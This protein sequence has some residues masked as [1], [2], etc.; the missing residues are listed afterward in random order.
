MSAEIPDSPERRARLAVSEYQGITPD[1]EMWSWNAE[2]LRK[3]IAACEG[4]SFDPEDARHHGWMHVEYATTVAFVAQREG[5][6]EAVKD[7]VASLCNKAE[8]ILRR[9][10][11]DSRHD[12]LLEA[13]L[14]RDA[15]AALV[16][17]SFFT[18]DRDLAE[19]YR[20]YRDR[21]RGALEAAL[22]EF[23]STGGVESYAH[24]HAAMLALMLVGQESQY[25]PLP[26]PP[27]ASSFTTDTKYRYDVLLMGSKLVA[28]RVGED[29][30]PWR[31]GLAYQDFVPSRPR[32]DSPSVATE[33]A[34]IGAPAH[35][36]GKQVKPEVKAVQ[37]HLVETV[38]AQLASLTE[39]VAAPPVPENHF[40]WYTTLTPHRNPY[41]AEKDKLE[42]ALSEVEMAHAEGNV[43]ATTAH[44]AGWMYVESGWGRRIQP[45]GNIMSPHGDLDRAED[46]LLHAYEKTA[47][48]TVER[49]EILL[50]QAALPMYKAVMAGEEEPPFDDYAAQLAAV[51]ENILGFY[52]TL[53]DKNTPVARR[54]DELI[55]ILTICLASAL[56]ETRSFIVVPSS[57]RQQQD[58]GWHITVWEVTAEG[59][60]AQK[61]GRMTLREDET[62]ETYAYGAVTITPKKL[63]QRHKDKRTVS[64]CTLIEHA[65]NA[66]ATDKELHMRERAFN[67]IWR[68]VAKVAMAAVR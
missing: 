29:T 15:A 27:R 10:A 42:A 43:S 59:A 45:Y 12:A 55:Q 23:A 61:Y 60:V 53:V 30:P 54:T 49:Y 7:D 14:L 33:V 19:N 4:V 21:Q 16:F 47:E 40:E 58:K 13:L 67:K 63:G 44:M 22:R 35:A 11:A 8:V 56:D 5:R 31:V 65:T 39:E 51:G 26:P 3:W 28:A 68:E 48:R 57:P 1:L 64:L 20:Q 52:A 50:A 25:L 32:R 34:K 17:K 2:V 9:A 36:D 6:R 18:N 66:P 41:V 46:M 24:A 37:N 62:I 38:S